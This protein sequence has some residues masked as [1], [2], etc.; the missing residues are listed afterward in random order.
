METF[1]ETKPRRDQ[2]PKPK[3]RKRGGH[4]GGG[5]AHYEKKRP[6]TAQEQ[7]DVQMSEPEK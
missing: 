6:Q 5:Q 1:T 7:D 2:N 4:G 3:N